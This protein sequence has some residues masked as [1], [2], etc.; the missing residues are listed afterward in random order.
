MI[1][2]TRLWFFPTTLGEK[3]AHTSSWAC[4]PT[5]VTVGIY[6]KILRKFIN[7]LLKL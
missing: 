5:E 2:R 7:E 3:H 6:S 1:P 4:L